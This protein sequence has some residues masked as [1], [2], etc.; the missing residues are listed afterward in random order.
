MPLCQDNRTHALP[1]ATYRA[2]NR[3]FDEDAKLKAG[4]ASCCKLRAAS[5]SEL[6]VA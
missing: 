6:Q 2:T 5:L 3:G 4:G 1:N